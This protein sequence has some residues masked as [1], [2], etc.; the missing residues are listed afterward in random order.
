MPFSIERPRF[1]IRA[2]SK[3]HLQSRRFIHWKPIPAD[4]YLRQR[5]RLVSHFQG[6]LVASPARCCLARDF[7]SP[8][9]AM[10]PPRYLDSILPVESRWITRNRAPETT[11]L[12]SWWPDVDVGPRT[13]RSRLGRG[14]TVASGPQQHLWSGLLRGLIW[15]SSPRSSCNTVDTEPSFFLRLLPPAPET[16]GSSNSN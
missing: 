10:G 1:R 12:W 16:S 7:G 11:R 14:P 4:C 9:Y 5:T 15:N 3:R 8:W 2:K 13:R 6:R